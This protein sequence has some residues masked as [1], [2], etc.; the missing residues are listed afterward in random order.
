MRVEANGHGVVTD[1]RLNSEERAD[2]FLLM[3]LRLAEGIDP[4]ALC[5]AVRPRARSG[6]D[7]HAARGRRHRRRRRRQAARDASRISG[8]R[9]RGGGSRGVIAI[10][11][12]AEPIR[13]PQG[14]TSVSAYAAEDDSYAPKLFGDPATGCCRRGD[15]HHRKAA[16]VGAVGAEPEQAVDAG[17]ARRVGQRFRRKTLRALR[18]RQRRDQRHR[19]IG[20]RRGAHRVGAVF[21]A[22]AAGE[23]AEARRIRRGIEPALQRRA[24]R[25]RADCP[26]ARCR[27]AGCCADSRRL[28]VSASAAADH[29]F[30]V[31]GDEQRVGRAQRLRHRRAPR[32][33]DRRRISR[34]RRCG[35]PCGRP[36]A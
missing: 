8:A 15:L 26:T 30:A 25:T 14:S 28:A 29:R 31:V 36:P 22:V 17:K 2:E 24:A 4:E 32:R 20:Q 21:G 16:L 5:G 1:D 7:R 18:S 27:A 34:T 11:R 33:R 10:V 6:P 3:G 13:R 12:E 35:R 9:C 23:G 19:V